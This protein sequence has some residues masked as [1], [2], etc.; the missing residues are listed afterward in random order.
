[1]RSGG[2]EQRQVKLV[3]LRVEV[4]VVVER[5]LRNLTDKL[6]EHKMIKACWGI[7]I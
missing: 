4:V 6:N 2:L 7:E 1:M 5:F 3:S